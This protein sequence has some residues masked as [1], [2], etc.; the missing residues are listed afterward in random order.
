[1]HLT[2]VGGGLAGL[3]AAV[4]AAD[5]GLSVRLYEAHATGRCRASGRLRLSRGGR[6]GLGVTRVAGECVSMAGL[7]TT[8][9]VGPGAAA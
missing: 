2:I 7:P 4:K 9:S 3:V 8:A 5:R 6:R 1:M